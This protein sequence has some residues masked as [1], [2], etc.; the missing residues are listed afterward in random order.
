MLVILVPVI[1][2]GREVSFGPLKVGS[3]FETK[4]SHRGGV[5]DD[6]LK[7]KTFSNRT[8]YTIY[9]TNRLR[10]AQK[11]DD[12]TWRFQGYSG[13]TFSHGEVSAR[14]NEFNLISQIVK[15]PD[16]VWRGV[17]VFTSLER[18]QEE[19]L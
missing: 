4:D 1:I 3:R 19:N 13:Q 9:R 15:R 10:S 18:F 11:I 12:V 17:A 2:Q 7:V 14:K 6:D 8:D 5:K 16:V